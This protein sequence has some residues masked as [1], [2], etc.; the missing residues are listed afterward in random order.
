[1]STK[2]ETKKDVLV[3]LRISRS[4]KDELDRLGVNLSDT[5]RKAFEVEVK[6]LLI[7]DAKNARK[8]K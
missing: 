3:N 2:V 6:R 1:M 8:K 5:A 7:I 4:V